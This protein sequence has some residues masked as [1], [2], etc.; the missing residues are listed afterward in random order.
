MC[1]KNIWTEKTRS[2]RSLEESALVRGLWFVYV[3]RYYSGAKVK[4]DEISGTYDTYGFKEQPLEERD[5]LE[6]LEEDGNLILKFK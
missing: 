5:D 2:N 4:E 6:D 3:I 1:W